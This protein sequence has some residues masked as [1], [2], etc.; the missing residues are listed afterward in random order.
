MEFIEPVLLGFLDRNFGCRDGGE[1]ARYERHLKKIRA[2]VTDESPYWVK[3]KAIHVIFK[4]EE[5]DLSIRTGEYIPKSPALCVETILLYV[6]KR[7]E[8]FVAS[9]RAESSNAWIHIPIPLPEFP[10]QKF[11]LQPDQ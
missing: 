7:I 3:E 6:K 5:A 1:S 8:K 9:N 2:F 10:K 11:L 4:I